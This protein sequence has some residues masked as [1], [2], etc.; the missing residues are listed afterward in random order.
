[1]LLVID[2]EKDFVL[3]RSVDCVTLPNKCVKS[4]SLRIV[5]DVVAIGNQYVVKLLRIKLS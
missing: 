4:L 1:M 2:V 3:I 5:F